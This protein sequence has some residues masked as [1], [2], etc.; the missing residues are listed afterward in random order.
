MQSDG[1]KYLEE[2]SPSLISELLRTFAE[3]DENSSQQ[4]SRKR[5]SSSVFGLDLAAD[6]AMAESVNPNG[7]RTRRRY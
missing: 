2:S 4:L 3:V 1:Y 5:S 6:G 7:R